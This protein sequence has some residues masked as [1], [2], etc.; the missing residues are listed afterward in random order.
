MAKWTERGSGRADLCQLQVQGKFYWWPGTGYSINILTWGT[1]CQNILTWSI[2]YQKYSRVKYQFRAHISA[3]LS[4]TLHTQIQEGYTLTPHKVFHDLFYVHNSMCIYIIVCI[5]VW[6]LYTVIVEWILAQITR[7]L[8]PFVL[9]TYWQ[10]VICKITWGP[11]R[12]RFSIPE[13]V[14]FNMRLP[15]D[16]LVANT[17][18]RPISSLWWCFL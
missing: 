7:K 2:N 12:V 17:D 16:S 6:L 11:E 3:S 9:A 15:G 14:K 5:Q 4:S 8:L 1:N 18:L 13:R 10:Q